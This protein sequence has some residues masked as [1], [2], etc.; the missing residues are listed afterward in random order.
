QVGTAQDTTYVTGP[1][2]FAVGVQDGGFINAQFDNLKV[3]PAG[4]VTAGNIIEL[5]NR[6]SGKA[7]EVA[8]KSTA[9]GAPI[10]QL[11]LTGLTNQQW[12]LVGHGTGYV[13]LV[14]VNSGKVLEVPGSSMMSGAALHQATDARAPNQEWQFQPTDSGYFKIINHASKDA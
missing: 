3:T 13:E 8:N 12:Q 14:N 10:D 1:G 7:L 2:G 5:V 9:N 11:T 4:T 6:S